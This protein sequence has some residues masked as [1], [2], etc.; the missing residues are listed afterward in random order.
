MSI[1]EPTAKLRVAKGTS[2]GLDGFQQQLF[3]GT[4]HLG[5]GRLTLA[6]VLGRRKQSLTDQSN[7]RY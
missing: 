4:E 3:A 6:L 1:A 7:S 5:H 2:V